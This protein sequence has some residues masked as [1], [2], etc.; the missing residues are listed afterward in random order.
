[1]DLNLINSD[2]DLKIDF[3]IPKPI[4][5]CCLTT[6]RRMNDVVNYDGYFRELAGINVSIGFDF[7]LDMCKKY[8]FS[9]VWCKIA[10]ILNSKPPNLDELKSKNS[11]F[12]CG[13]RGVNYQ[14]Q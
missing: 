12:F 14:N 3:D 10:I 5:R 13:Y 4:C 11:A 7:Y 2:D 9:N 1:M 6:D 8:P